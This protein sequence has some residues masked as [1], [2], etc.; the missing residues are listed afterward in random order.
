MSNSILNLT[1]R[2]RLIVMGV[3]TAVILG[4]V[5]VEISSKERII[6]E[7]TTILLRIAP[8]DP[9]SLLQGD[10][11]ALRYSM[12][13]AVASAADTAQVT[14]GRAIVELGEYDEAS[15]VAIYG[16][17]QLEQGQHLLRF[18]KRGESVRLASDAYFFEEG[19]WDVY[20][21]ARFGELRVNAD[22]EAV[23]IGLR[24]S[25]GERLGLPVHSPSPD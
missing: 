6:S 16:G 17:Q 12:V 25:S 23:L 4:F 24:N 9:R 15:F 5:N 2:T 7:G 13:G 10:Y 18:R 1:D 20:S 14:D 19:Q 22:G 11:M 21:G 8:R 3:M